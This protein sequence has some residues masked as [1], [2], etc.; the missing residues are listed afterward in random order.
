MKKHEKFR[1]I[2]INKLGKTP[3]YYIRET[4][5]F[6]RI[7]ED[8]IHWYENINNDKGKYQLQKT[9]HHITGVIKCAL[10]HAKVIV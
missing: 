6:D 5:L 4:T 9:N 7:A 10:A 3:I 2:L 8:D 1:D